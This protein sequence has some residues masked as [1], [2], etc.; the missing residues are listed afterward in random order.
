MSLVLVGDIHGDFNVLDKVSHKH[1]TDTVIQVGDIGF[2]PQLEDKWIQ[3]TLMSHVKFYF[4]EGNHDWLPPLINHSSEGIREVWPKLKYVPRGTVLTLEGYR[5]GFLGGAK[6]IDRAWRVQ[7]SVDHGWF[8]S[9]QV[10]DSEV[11]LL[12]AQDPDIYITH[13]APASVVARNFNP[14]VPSKMFRH[15]NWIDET[16]IRLD[17]IANTCKP[18]YCGHMHKSVKDGNV[19]IL[20]INEILVIPSKGE[21]HE[22]E[23]EP[24]S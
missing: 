24:V 9:E 16:A 5:I 23:A 21:S 15:K 1:M 22:Q 6:S 10:T 14:E 18:M 4:I 2:W 11:D 20:A 13:A 19:T 8:E 7:D 12:I 3:E 17:K